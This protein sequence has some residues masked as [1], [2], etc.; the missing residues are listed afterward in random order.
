MRQ[1]YRLVSLI[2]QA[3]VLNHPI[4]FK[5]TH[6]KYPRRKK[7]FDESE[8]KYVTNIP[9]IKAKIRLERKSPIDKSGNLRPMKAENFAQ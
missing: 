1:F 2:H 3:V 8:R 4:A 6:E 7:I 9:P 5:K